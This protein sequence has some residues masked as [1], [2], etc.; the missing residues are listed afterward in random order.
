[1]TTQN[2]PLL[3]AALACAGCLGLNPQQSTET[4]RSTLGEDKSGPTAEAGTIKENPNE[5]KGCGTEP[6]PSVCQGGV[7]GGATSCKTSAAWKTAVSD[8][9]AAS[10]LA[11][12]DLYPF[13]G[14]GPDS[15]R[16]AE[17]SCCDHPPRPPPPPPTQVC[18]T[19]QLGGASSPCKTESD[20]KSAVLNACA[21]RKL[22]L[23]TFSTFDACGTTGFRQAKVLC[24]K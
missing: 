23:S 3:I 12:V 4:Q 5:E 1:M 18:E 17:Y 11:P 6:G 20:W 2:V 19:Q 21:A 8:L 15:F 14:C 22:E 7:L 13:D 24:C 16:Q 9:C 10:K